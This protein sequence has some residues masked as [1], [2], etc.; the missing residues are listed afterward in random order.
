MIDTYKLTF[1]LQCGKGYGGKYVRDSG[2]QREKQLGLAGCIKEKLTEELILEMAC[3][4]AVVLSIS[5]VLEEK[6]SFPHIKL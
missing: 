3:E 1:T 5:L 6:W 4:E 2:G